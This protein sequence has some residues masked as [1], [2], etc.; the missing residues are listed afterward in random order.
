[1]LWLLPLVLLPARW[2][3]RS[4][5]AA[6]LVLGAPL[7]AFVIFALWVHFAP[8][9]ALQFAVP[10]AV[11]VPVALHR[12][13]GLLPARPRWL[14]WIGS[15]VASGLVLF[16]A[17]QH[18]S[19]SEGMLVDNWY[20]Q[21]F[22]KLV[23]WAQANVGEDDAMLECCAV[24]LETVFYP[25]RL[26]DGLPNTYGMSEPLCEEYVTSPPRVAGTAWLLA[27][28]NQIFEAP[29]ARSIAAAGWHSE[30]FITAF[31]TPCRIWRYQGQQREEPAQPDG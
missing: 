14:P 26:N 1:M 2:G 27:G 23:R 19:R 31:H 29:S 10:I 18:W 5:A 30:D 21:G 3:K 17:L 4:S 25:R 8:R 9:Y 15:A 7:G 20:D 12:A 24:A 6:L 22:H 13:F 16:M 28:S 11:F